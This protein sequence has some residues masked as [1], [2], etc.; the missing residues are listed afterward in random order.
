MIALEHSFLMTKQKNIL[1]RG[2]NMVLIAK[3]K[4]VNCENQEM[5]LLF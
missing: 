3:S 2:G 1:C 5:C 4:L